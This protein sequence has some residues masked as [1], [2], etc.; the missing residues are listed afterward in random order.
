[1][2]I[3]PQQDPSLSRRW[4]DTNARVDLRRRLGV[5]APG[6][7]PYGKSIKDI[8]PNGCALSESFVVRLHQFVAILARLVVT[9]IVTNARV[10]SFDLSNWLCLVPVAGFLSTAAFSDSQFACFRF[11]PHRPSGRGGSSASKRSFRHRRHGAQSFD[12]DEEVPEFGGLRKKGAVSNHPLLRYRPVR[13]RSR[14]VVPLCV[15]A[16]FFSTN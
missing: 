1:M 9:S 2:S 10:E 6:L 11:F 8:V 5:R 3:Y 12:P 16:Y 13:T 7:F 14:S 4:L 15:S